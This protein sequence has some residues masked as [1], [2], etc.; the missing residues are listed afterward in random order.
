MDLL[1]ARG[2]LHWL[3]PRFVSH[4]VKHFKI[5]IGQSKPPAQLSQGVAYADT[6]FG[7][8]RTFQNLAY[9]RLCAAAV[10]SCPNTQWTVHFIRLSG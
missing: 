3:S 7:L 5:L 10:I 4:L 1:A 8:Y 6:L 2:R 9:F